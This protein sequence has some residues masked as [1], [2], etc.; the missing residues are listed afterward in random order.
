VDLSFRRVAGRFVLAA[1]VCAAA[2]LV[3][4]GGDSGPKGVTWVVDPRPLGS[5]LRHLDV[6]IA[7]GDEVQ[8]WQTG[9]W[10][11][12]RAIAP[13]RLTTPTPSGEVTV[14]LDVVTANGAQRIVHRA[15]PARGATVEIVV[16]ATPE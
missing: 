15:T 9:A 14:T 6:T 13:L 16:G 3:F 7:V 5:D 11:R 4:R 12:T 1:G 10:D 2:I 8:A